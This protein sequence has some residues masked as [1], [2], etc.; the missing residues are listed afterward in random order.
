MHNRRLYPGVIPSAVD[1]AL[2]QYEEIGT[3]YGFETMTHNFL[4][5]SVTII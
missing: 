1:G 5:L 2:T 3:P 4:F